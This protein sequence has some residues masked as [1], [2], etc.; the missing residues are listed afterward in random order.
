ML[1]LQKKGEDMTRQLKVSVLTAALVAGP[2]LAFAAANIPDVKGVWA[3]KTGTI[4]VG[5]GGHFPAAQP[6]PASSPVM[7][8][9]APADRV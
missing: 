9:G 8:S 3:G 2:L 5:S 6:K 1:L 7:K 4:V